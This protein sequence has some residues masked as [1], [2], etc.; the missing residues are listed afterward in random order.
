MS[1]REPDVDFQFTY[2]GYMRIKTD[3][4]PYT[5]CRDLVLMESTNVN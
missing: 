5:G 3:V 1:T 4:N 2:W